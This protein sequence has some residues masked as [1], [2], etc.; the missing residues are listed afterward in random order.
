MANTRLLNRYEWFDGGSIWYNE[1]AIDK[2]RNFGILNAN[3]R[4]MVVGCTMINDNDENRLAVLVI[5]VWIVGGRIAWI[6]VKFGTALTIRCIYERNVCEKCL[7]SKNQKLFNVRKMAV[8]KFLEENNCQYALFL[9]HQTQIN[10]KWMVFLLF[11]LYFVLLE[12][13]CWLIFWVVCLVCV[14]IYVSKNKL[15]YFRGIQ[16]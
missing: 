15:E 4:K 16:H 14:R 1:C 6:A 13:N 3:E 2:K 8:D 9:R 12:S 10:W 7:R 11:L 5:S